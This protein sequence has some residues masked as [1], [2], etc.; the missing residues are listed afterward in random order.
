MLSLLAIAACTE[1][2][3]PVNPLH[4]EKPNLSIAADPGHYVSSYPT[5]YFAV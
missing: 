4:P 3:L 1:A 5:E 2:R